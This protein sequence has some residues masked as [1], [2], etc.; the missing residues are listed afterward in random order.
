MS[1]DHTGL[2]WFKGIISSLRHRRAAGRIQNNNIKFLSWNM[3]RSKHIPWIAIPV[4][5]SSCE[6]P[7]WPG[8][9]ALCQ[10]LY[11]SSSPFPSHLGGIKVHANEKDTVV[12]SGH[13]TELTSWSP[14]PT[15]IPGKQSWNWRK[16]ARWKILG[17]HGATAKIDMLCW[18]QCSEKGEIFVGPFLFLIHKLLVW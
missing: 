13:R 5:S 18:L 16:N 17:R 14:A 3:W 7:H 9:S 12:K 6:S 8:I 15:S 1:R 4:A 11:S 10:D 2:A